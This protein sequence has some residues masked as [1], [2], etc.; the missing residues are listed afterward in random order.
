MSR[1]ELE[2]LKKRDYFCLNFVSFGGKELQEKWSIVCETFDGRR[3][4]GSDEEEFVP[5]AE[6][7][8]IGRMSDDDD[9]G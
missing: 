6:I 5:D 7:V 9:W 3:E 4:N 1:E 8:S 2:M